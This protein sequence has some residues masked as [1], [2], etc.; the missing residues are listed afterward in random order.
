MNTYTISHGEKTWQ[1]KPAAEAAPLIP[2]GVIRKAVESDDDLHQAAIMFAT[3]KLAAPKDFVDYL[4]MLPMVEA[5]NLL[6][7]WF[8]WAPEGEEPAGK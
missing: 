3:V 6:Q 2:A 5:M 8:E 1:L 7:P 4:D